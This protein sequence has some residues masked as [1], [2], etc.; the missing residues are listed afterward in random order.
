MVR[1]TW[2]RRTDQEPL[3]SPSALS[4]SRRYW[5]SEVP[6]GARMWN[7]SRTCRSTAR[8]VNRPAAAWISIACRAEV[9]AYSALT[10]LAFIISSSHGMPWSSRLTAWYS[11]V[12]AVIRRDCISPSLILTLVR[13]F[14][15]RP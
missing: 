4:A 14:S 12:R 5:T 6:A 13:S 8:S 10:A 1:A 15:G 11:A 2:A 3:P 7:A 9:M